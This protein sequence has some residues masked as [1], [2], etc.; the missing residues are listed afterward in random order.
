[1]IEL[2][3]DHEYQDGNYESLLKKA[4]AETLKQLGGAGKTSLTIVLTDDGHLQKLNQEYLGIDAPTDVLSFPAEKASSQE[5]EGY[6][7]DILISQPRAAAQAKAG[8]HAM[9]QELE[10]LTVHAV[11]HLLGYDHADE[12]DKERMWSAQREIL[13]TLG[14]SL[15]P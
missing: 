14:N 11:L 13:N 8:G 9:E 10:L 12:S 15:N 3:V 5:D 7:G 6:L 1:M 4:A 2:Q